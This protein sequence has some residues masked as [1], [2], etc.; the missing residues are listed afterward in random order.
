MSDP[1]TAL[2][3]VQRPS[4]PSLELLDDGVDEYGNF[5]EQ[6]TKLQ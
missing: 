6:T 3:P 4:P 2:V 5:S 1:A